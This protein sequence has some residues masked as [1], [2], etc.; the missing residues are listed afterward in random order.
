[1][2]TL[3]KF[4]LIAGQFSPLHGFRPAFSNMAADL[5][6]A[7]DCDSARWKSVRG[8]TNQGY[9]VGQFHK[10]VIMS[11]ANPL[12]FNSGGNLPAQKLSQNQVASLGTWKIHT[13]LSH[14]S[15]LRYAPLISI[16]SNR[17]HESQ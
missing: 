15:L 17:S 10:S 11:Q 6:A 16:M 2:E 1:M 9:S 4:L 7:C 3:S 8:L 12:V 14:S 13:I 5:A